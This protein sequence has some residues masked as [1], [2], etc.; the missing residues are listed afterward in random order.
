MN[1]E[2]K[3][4]ALRDL[5]QRL[6]IPLEACIAVGDGA[7]DLSMMAAAGLGVAFH[8]KPAVRAASPIEVTHCGLDAVCYLLGSEGEFDSD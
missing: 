6:N 2:Y 4:A 1:R 7:N 3:A 8:A 5:A